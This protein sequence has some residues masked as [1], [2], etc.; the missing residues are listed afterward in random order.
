[1]T[2][3]PTGQDHAPLLSTAW[4]E[5]PP[6]VN[7]MLNPALISTL[8]VSAADSYTRQTQ[9]G[10]PWALS[11]I[12][13]PLA[14][15]R[16]TRQ[17]LPATSRTHLSNWVSMHPILRAGFPGRAQALVAPVR[18]GLRFSL[19]HHILRLDGDRLRVQLQL[20]K[21]EPQYAEL[22][23]ILSHARL[24][25]RWLSTVDTATTFALLGVGP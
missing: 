11:F 21:V 19:R 6:I 17:A 14:L 1:M 8:L 25:G 13:A 22:D 9:E 12:A 16:G 18:A 4:G 5:R 3:P 24:L 23:D 15:H 20:R 2:T 7:G 10:M